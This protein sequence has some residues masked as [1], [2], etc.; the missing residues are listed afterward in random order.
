MTPLTVAV[1]T[2]SGSMAGGANSYESAVVRLL[3]DVAPEANLQITVLSP[4]SVSTREG[5]VASDADAT[6]S[7][8]RVSKALSLLVSLPLLR[9]MSRWLSV[10]AFE[11]Q[12]LRLR[13]DLVYFA[14]PNIHALG[15]RR[16]PFIFT[17]WDMGH[18]ELAHF[19][20]FSRGLES[21]VRERL[22]SDA[23]PRAFRTMTDS[24]RTGKELENSY[25]V[26]PSKWASLGMAF[27]VSIADP[28][29]YLTPT[30]PYFVYPAQKWPHKNH[31]TLLRAMRQVVDQVPDARLFLVGS[32]KAHQVPI[33]EW[34]AELGLEGHVEDLG[35]V[36][37][38]H[39]SSLISG[40]TALVMP[41]LLGPTN[42]PPI[43]AALLGV[44]SIVSDAHYFDENLDDYVTTVSALDVDAWAQEMIRSIGSPRKSPWTHNPWAKNTL[45][46]L[47]NDFRQY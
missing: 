33:S 35:F 28:G 25:R 31:V 19:P 2:K 27:S 20:E 6:Y 13:A 4:K 12:L 3:R 44:P 46:D 41:S 9:S 15:V 17:V 42:L 11:R 26:Q 1:V 38:A 36:S 37:D 14:S 5:T 43:E 45:L 22:Y 24:V 18:R 47:I 29:D 7:H 21:K 32:D 10:S 23:I 39:L 40:A 34:V 16:I 8:S 30:G